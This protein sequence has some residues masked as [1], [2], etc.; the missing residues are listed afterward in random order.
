MP[1]PLVLRKMC[2]PSPGIVFLFGTH[3]PPDKPKKEA[4]DRQK[5]VKRKGYRVADEQ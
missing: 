3:P 2:L 1:G 5:R 4:Q